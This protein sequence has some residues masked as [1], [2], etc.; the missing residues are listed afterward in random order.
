MRSRAMQLDS[1]GDKPEW[2]RTSLYASTSVR[3]NKHLSE[4]GAFELNV[5]IH[6]IVVGDFW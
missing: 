4:M 1:P 6:G 2:A 5:S 3:L